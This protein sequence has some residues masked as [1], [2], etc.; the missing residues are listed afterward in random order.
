M[1]GES[2]IIRKANNIYPPLTGKCQVI[3]TTVAS[4][5]TALLA[6]FKGHYVEI[7]ADGTDVYALFGIDNTVVADKTATG[8]GA[9]VCVKLPADQPKSYFIPFAND[10]SAVTH[11]ALQAASGTPNVRI[12][13]SD[14][15]TQT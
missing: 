1:S 8:T 12:A 5:A 14:S 10:P 2:E 15:P 9:T 11:I 6:A 7:T 3:A 4:A 13:L